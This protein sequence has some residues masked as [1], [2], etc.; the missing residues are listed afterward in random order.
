M[1]EPAAVNQEMES[2]ALALPDQ[3]KMIMVV[4]NDSME[5]ANTFKL[6]IKAM[7]K[8]VDEWF[9]PLA[10]KAF[11]AHRAITGKWNEVKAP[12]KQADDHVTAQVKKYLAEVRR[13]EMEEAERLREIA[14]KEAEAEQLRAALEAEANGNVE[15]A[16]EILESEPVYVAPVPVFNTPKVDGRLYRTQLKVKVKDRWQF[17]EYVD[18]NVLLECLN[19]SA[20]Q[21]IENGL[22]RKAKALGRAFSSPGCEVYEA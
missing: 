12:L 18:S 15:E 6:D 2:K 5:R 8:E 10:D 7:I 1:S 20:W 22:S 17:L 3:A 13:K 4:D 14:R 16:E 9:K 19:E 11:Q 21:T